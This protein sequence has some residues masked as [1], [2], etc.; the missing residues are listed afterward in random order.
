MAKLMETYQ[1]K[2]SSSVIRRRRVVADRVARNRTFSL[3]KRRTTVRPSLCHLHRSSTLPSVLI[4]ATR[5]ESAAD[6]T[7]LVVVK[8]R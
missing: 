6:E 5:S 7:L 3:G 4:V 2:V 1:T 8:Q